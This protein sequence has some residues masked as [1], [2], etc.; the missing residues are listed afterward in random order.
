M[1]TTKRAPTERIRTADGAEIGYRI[2][3]HGPLLVLHPPGWGIG[4]TPYA[5]TM[6]P[7]EQHYT[8][9]YV[10][11]RGAA[12]LPTPPDDARLDIAASVTDL[13]ALRQHLGC[14]QFALAGHSHG[15]LIALHYSLRHPD[16]VRR[17]LLLSAQLIGVAADEDEPEPN[18]AASLPPEVVT[19]M[20]YLA[21]RGGLDAIFS[22]RSDTEA[23]DFLSRILPLYFAD[24]T[25]K[26]PLA[27]ALDG[28]R[29]PVR[30]LGKVTATDM[31]FPLPVDTLRRHTVPTVIVA[32][33]RDRFCP[34]AEARGLAKIM[35]RATLLTFQASG[36]FPWLE[37]RDAFFSRVSDAMTELDVV[38]RDPSRG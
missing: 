6:T 38:S 36:H 35:P 13:E 28:I 5:E 15:G 27:R 34:P 31:G 25:L 22:L 9:V 24:P 12:G 32:G 4:A 1:D 16:R 18:S 7:L 21:D 17:L 23:T 26:T 14:E 8:V 33:L 3:G 11:P 10:W 2:E 19:A 37:E 29:L 20:R 30:T